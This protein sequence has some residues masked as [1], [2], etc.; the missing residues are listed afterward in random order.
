MWWRDVFI[1]WKC[2]LFCQ[3]AGWLTQP[4]GILCPLEPFLFF[5]FWAFLSEVLSEVSYSFIT[6]YVHCPLG[7]LLR[8]TAVPGSAQWQLR[9]HL[10]KTV[11]GEARMVT[12]YGNPGEL[13]CLRNSTASWFWLWRPL[14][15]SQSCSQSSGRRNCCRVVW[16][17]SYHPCT[18]DRL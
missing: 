16:V 5:N 17:I 11:V 13:V 14:R 10:Q 8:L 7:L 3:N 6:C 2:S 15:T 12:W 1:P 9:F 18:A 4:C